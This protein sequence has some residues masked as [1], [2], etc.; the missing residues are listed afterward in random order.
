[1]VVAVAVAVVVVVALA[2]GV[3]DGVPVGVLQAIAIT[4]VT[5]IAEPPKIHRS[6]R[7]GAAGPEPAA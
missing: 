2:D 3:G 1:V 4:P 6:C 5:V 7:F